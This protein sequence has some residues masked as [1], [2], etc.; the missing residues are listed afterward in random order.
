MARQRPDAHQ[1]TWEDVSHAVSMWE[2]SMGVRIRSTITWEPRL[3]S[4]A[5]VEVVIEEGGTIG[6]GEELVRVREAFP[7]KRAT[8]QPGAVLWAISCAVRCLE[9]EPWL[10]SRKMRRDANTQS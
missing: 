6:R 2:A 8:G 1:N 3:S 5:A 4:G 7:A 10:W 9:R